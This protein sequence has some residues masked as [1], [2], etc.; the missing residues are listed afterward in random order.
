MVKEGIKN[1]EKRHLSY[2]N[3]TKKQ[4]EALTKLKESDDIVITRADKGGA[5]VNWGIEEYLIEAKPITN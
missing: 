2:D 4:R 1:H 5:I 3:L